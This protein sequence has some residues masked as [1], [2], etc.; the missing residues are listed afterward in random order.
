MPSRKR[1]KVIQKIKTNLTLKIKT[2]Q[3]NFSNKK[4][5]IKID[6]KVFYEILSKYIQ[7]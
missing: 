1:K 7:S 5:N 2:Q 4:K 6:L 3:G